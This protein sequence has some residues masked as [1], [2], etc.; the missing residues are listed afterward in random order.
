MISQWAEDLRWHCGGLV[1]CWATCSVFAEGGSLRLLA[2]WIIG[3]SGGRRWLCSN[4]AYLDYC[5][6]LLRIEPY[7]CTC[8]YGQ[9]ECCGVLLAASVMHILLSVFP[10]AFWK[11]NVV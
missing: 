7:S 4:Y 6:A 8:F 5:F 11:R 10:S 3:G 2:R 1:G 9:M